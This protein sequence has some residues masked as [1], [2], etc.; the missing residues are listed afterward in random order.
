V[1]IWSPARA[2]AHSAQSAAVGWFERALAVLE[3]QPRTRERIALAVDLRLELRYALIPYLYTESRRTYDTG[4]A[5][6]RPLYY[7]WPEAP[8]AYRAESQYM[9]GESMMV[10]PIVSS[11][12]WILARTERSVAAPG[13]LGQ[14]FTG[15][16][17]RGRPPK[18]CSRW[19]RS[20][21][22]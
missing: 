18:R 20:P 6:L 17:L 1:S 12:D 9:F 7:D 21:S 19:T 8:E 15:D 22:T 3:R 11:G 14:W 2:F 5:F 10:A 4:V 13:H 16:V